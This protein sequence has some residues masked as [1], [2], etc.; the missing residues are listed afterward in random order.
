MPTTS[1]SL[2][3]GVFHDGRQIQHLALRPIRFDDVPH[4]ADCHHMPR[5][6]ALLARLSGEPVDAVSIMTI[7][8]A[9]L[10]LTALT[11]H[12]AI[13]QPK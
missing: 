10:A 3:D 13:H 8:D 4:V 5:A 11:G 6:I 1:V 12:L 7:D 2:R 9:M